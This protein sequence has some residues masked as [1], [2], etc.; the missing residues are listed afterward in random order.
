MDDKTEPP[1]RSGSRDEASSEA[2]SDHDWL[3]P[4]AGA[5]TTD[6]QD[7]SYDAPGADAGA[8]E[9]GRDGAC[10]QPAPQ[11]HN[12]QDVSHDK[13]DAPP[14]ARV[15]EGVSAPPSPPSDDHPDGHP[16][17]SGKPP[18]RQAAGGGDAPSLGERISDGVAKIFFPVRGGSGAH[19]MS[20][21]GSNSHTPSGSDGRRSPYE[22]HCGSNPGDEHCYLQ[23]DPSTFNVRGKNYMRDKRKEP[24]A[25]GASEL[26]A[27]ELF[28]AKKMVEDV[29][30][31]P[32]EWT[33]VLSLA[34]GLFLGKEML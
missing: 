6:A 25:R 10:A 3:A 28:R 27:V 29:G 22:L 15:S 23:L 17:Q 13:E 24:S 26:L 16:D 8:G 30:T 21:G 32:G 2:S 5:A 7:A 18:A 12:S 19:S 34:S 1:T 9:E 14:S 20:R 4:P 33:C 11:D 31:K